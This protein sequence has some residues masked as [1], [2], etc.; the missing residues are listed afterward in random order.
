MKKA[1]RNLLLISAFFFAL[2][3]GSCT[4]G[5][6]YDERNKLYVET[7]WFAYDAGI[8]V[9][10]RRWERLGEALFLFSMIFL[11]TSGVVWYRRKQ[12]QDLGNSILMR[13]E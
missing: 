10:G 7:Y 13:K 6:E 9:Y 11:I 5:V 4:F 8:A 12:S 3:I 1:I 2:S